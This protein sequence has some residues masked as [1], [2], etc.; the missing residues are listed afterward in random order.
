MSDTNLVLE[1]NLEGADLLHRGKV[2]DVYSVGDDL[3]IVA[4][5]RISAYDCVL[6]DGIPHKGALLTQLSLFWYE[7][8]GDVVGNHLISADVT[9]FPDPLPRFTDCLKGRSMLVK[10]AERF[11]VECVVRGYLI[12]SGW[13]DYQTTGAV[14]GI[15][16]DPGLE[17]AAQLPCSIFTPSTK[18]DTG[19]DENISRQQMDKI[20]GEAWA[21][22]LE[23]VSQTLYRRAADYAR[24]RGIIIADTK[25]EFGLYDGELLLID[26]ALT[27]DSSRFWPADSYV[28]G[29]SPPSF[30]KQFVRDFLDT[31]DWDHSPPAPAL[32][33]EV[34]HATSKKYL[35]SY[36]RLAGV[37]L[38]GSE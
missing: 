26:E 15:S 34:V 8:L 4:T 17:L 22:Q 37:P 33:E 2:R 30:D 3:L 9:D 25:F 32:P 24:S 5:D 11:D 16:L 38:A 20:V 23:E 6:P 21:E 1:T 18:A 27:P 19:H 29:Q 28:P 13:R 12:G 10:R 7:Q 14:C 36:H 31:L 35:E